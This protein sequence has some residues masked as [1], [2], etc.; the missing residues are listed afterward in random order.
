M[1]QE[2]VCWLTENVSE[3]VATAF[4]ILC[5]ILFFINNKKVGKTG[6]DLKAVVKFNT[7]D[8]DDKIVLLKGYLQK[9]IDEV[10][11]TKAE[12]LTEKARVVKENAGIRK[13]YAKL[14]KA[15]ELQNERIKRLEDL[16]KI[17]ALNSRELVNSG[18]TK[19]VVDILE[20]ASENNEVGNGLS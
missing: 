20:K 9:E 2:I 8:T 1:E 18:T 19:T 6:I 7:K 14:R 4:S 5:Y 17:C 15:N 16:L 11:E 10:N 13:S 12:L 3:V